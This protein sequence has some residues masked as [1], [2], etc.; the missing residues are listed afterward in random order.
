M[1]RSIAVLRAPIQIRS[2]NKWHEYMEERRHATTLL[3]TAMARLR[4]GAGVGA[5]ARWR[6]FTALQRKRDLA[7]SS[8]TWGG[9][10]EALAL[11]FK[12]LQ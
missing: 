6:E 1:D 5:L 10:C 12:C 8:T 3:S 9:P 2:F 4:Y 11:A 7:A